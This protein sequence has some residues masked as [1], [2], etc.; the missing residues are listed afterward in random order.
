MNTRGMSSAREMRKLR[1]DREVERLR[2]E[3]KAK[4]VCAVQNWTEDGLHFP[5]EDRN[6]TVYVG[7][8]WM[9]GRDGGHWLAKFKKPT[10]IV[11]RIICNN[12]KCKNMTSELPSSKLAIQNWKVTQALHK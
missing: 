1:R 4:V 2:I 10:G 7:K 12:D 11:Y 6:F 3:R 8:C 5:D 9:C